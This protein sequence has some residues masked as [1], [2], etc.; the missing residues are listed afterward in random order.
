MLIPRRW[1]DRKDPSDANRTPRMLLYPD[2]VA[3]VCLCSKNNIGIGQL[4][5]VANADTS[6]FDEPGL[7]S[8]RPAEFYSPML[9]EPSTKPSTVSRSRLMSSEISRL[10]NVLASP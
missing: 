8:F 2:D 9:T 5:A 3:Y 6:S 4:L 10:R 1:V 7:F